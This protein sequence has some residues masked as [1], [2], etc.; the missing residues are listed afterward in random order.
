MKMKKMFAIAL[1]LLLPLLAMICA[2]AEE[3]V[4]SHAK[5]Y[6]LITPASAAYPDDGK[7]LVDG[8]FGTKPDGGSGYYSSGAYI[9]FNQSD[10]NSAGNFVILLDL[11]R[12][13]EDISGFTVGFLNEIGV[14]IYAPKSVTFSVCDERNGE[15]ESIGTL[16]TEKPTDATDAVTYAETLACDDASGRYVMVEIEHLGELVG[17]DGEVVSAGWTFIDEIIVYS[18]GNAAGDDDDSSSGQVGE[19]SSSSGENADSSVV[20][21]SDKTPDSTESEIPTPGDRGSIFALLMLALSA[22]AMMA[23]LFVGR[24]KNAEF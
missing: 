19:D 11:G 21:E 22:F 23:A 5:H 16:N 9:G 13:Y 18:S 24:R 8:I 7:L 17:K 20:D 2:S 10:V 6:D 1:A 14:G 15:Y 3:N 12:N 4:I